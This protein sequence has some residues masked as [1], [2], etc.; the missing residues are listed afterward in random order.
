MRPDTGSCAGLSLPDMRA[1]GLSDR[2]S[3]CIDAWIA[4]AAIVLLASPCLFLSY[5][6]MTD[7]PQHAA[8][9]AIL[10]HLG[11]PAWG[12]DEWYERAY[13]RTLYLLAYG[14]TIAL[15]QVL[16]AELAVRA[17]AFVSSISY[18][19]GAWALL[20]ATGR[21]GTLALLTLP[22]VYDRTFFWGFANFNLA[23]GLALLAIAQ[24]ERDAD[25]SPRRR[26][27][28]FALCC[29]LVV[30][31]VYAI[32]IVV[33]Y[34]A[35]RFVV[36]DRRQLLSWLAPL[37]PLAIGAAV[38]L[39]MGIGGPERGPV[40]FTSLRERL[41][42]FE[43]S[44]LGGYPN[45]SDELLFVSMLAITAVFAARSVPFTT[46]RWRAAERWERIFSVYV[47]IHLLLYFVLPLHMPSGH[48]INFRHAL[49]AVAFLPLLARPL[50]GHR[51][52]QLAPWLLGG[53]VALSFAVNLPQLI[54]FDREAR[55]FDRVIAQLPDAPRVFF[56]DW[57]TQGRVVETHPY[58]HF[59]AYIQARRGG[60]I[61]FGFSELF[62]NIPVRQRS[63]SG[64]PIAPPEV[65]WDPARYDYEAFGY[66][67]DYVLMRGR[68]R[69]T[70][71]AFPYERVYRRPP[72][73][74][75]RRRE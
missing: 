27:G 74:L 9:A 31:H 66:F 60:L 23:I 19:L 55:A 46:A 65:E 22:M 52:R 32:A 48:F 35:I 15:G 25:A 17:L 71:S 34:L 43:N 37:S 51:S 29:V 36:A 68:G 64:I 30:T 59:H 54:A 11:D 24:L 50:T 73:R 38:W 40:V 45:A 72:W 41:L 44:V 58:H 4:P 7:M 39:A 70:G 67:Y 10:E 53:L 26:A 20:R 28:L 62:W 61:S 1:F 49:L 16:P 21:P 13:D 18:P 12:F 14:F 56:L 33:G 8:I 75:F 5:L 6:P 69:V 47:V 57:D 63:D 42:E 2:S 3:A